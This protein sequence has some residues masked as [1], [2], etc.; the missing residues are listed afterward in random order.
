M[1]PGGAVENNYAKAWKLPWLKIFRNCVG[2]HKSCQVI[3]ADKED[4][5]GDHVEGE[6]VWA[7]VCRVARWNVFFA[8]QSVGHIVWTH[9]VK[10]ADFWNK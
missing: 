4:D 5:A 1:P 6:V 7:R 2:D 9:F 8:R 10:F 3:D